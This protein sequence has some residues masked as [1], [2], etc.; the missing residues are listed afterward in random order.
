M[1]RSMLPVAATGPGPWWTLLQTCNLEIISQLL[2]EPVI[3]AQ[4]L[5][6]NPTTEL[7]TLT[8][9]S[10]T[11]PSWLWSLAQTLLLQAMRAIGNSG[12]VRA[13]RLRRTSTLTRSEQ[14]TEMASTRTSLS[15]SQSW[16]SQLDASPKKRESSM[17]KTNEQAVEAKPVFDGI[18]NVRAAAVSW[19]GATVRG[20]SVACG[21]GITSKKRLKKEELIHMQT[22]ILKKVN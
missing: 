10:K 13:G 8:Q 4:R 15:T 18:G 19:N 6:I 17:W 5:M 21:I 20:N 2:P 12:M 11:Q 3:W 1:V 9:P 14:P 22:S 7:E 16:R